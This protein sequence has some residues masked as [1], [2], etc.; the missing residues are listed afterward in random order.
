MYQQ[1]METLARKLC[2]PLLLYKKLI[3]HHTC[4]EK[5]DKGKLL[6][7]CSLSAQTVIHEY[8]NPTHIAQTVTARNKFQ[9]NKSMPTHTWQSATRKIRIQ[10]YGNEL[11][12]LIEHNRNDEKYRSGW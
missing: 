2:V 9:K 5:F 3:K 10:T 1:I 11:D 7:G 6:V 8:I 4:L 12:R